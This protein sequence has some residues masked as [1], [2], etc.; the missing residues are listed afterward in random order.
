MK[1]KREKMRHVAPAEA[2]YIES[3]AAV[4]NNK[5]KNNIEEQIK[6]D[7]ARKKRDGVSGGLLS[8][9][10]TNLDSPHDDAGSRAAK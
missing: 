10:C 7:A 1:W 2:W 8:K 5:R 9:Y 6:H 4:L 3:I